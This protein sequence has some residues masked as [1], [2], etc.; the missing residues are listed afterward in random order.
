MSNLLAIAGCANHQHEL[1]NPVAVRAKLEE[2]FNKLW[3]EQRKKSRKLN[4]YNQVKK[5]S[6]ISF[7]P[8]LNISDTRDRKCLMRLRSSS[9]RLNCET[10]RYITE[11]NLDKNQCSYTWF[12]RCE[13]CTTEEAVLLTHLPLNDII[14]E[15]EHHLLI[16]CPRYHAQRVSLSEETKSL[17][18]RDENHE[19][20][21]KS[22]H[23]KYFGR[24]V[25]KIFDIRFP[26]K[27]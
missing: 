18:L 15:D 12:K 2:H 5:H 7:E 25:R 3:D 13:F 11:S 9:H 10:A 24:Y 21:Y 6:T 19:E 26:K 14:E 16:T 20:L 23:V 17:L 4:Y 22:R 8:F 1:A 27:K